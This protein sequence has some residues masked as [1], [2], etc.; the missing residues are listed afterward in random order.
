M[1]NGF[2]KNITNTKRGDTF[3]KH[4][5]DQSKCG[6][7][8]YSPHLLFV[9]LSQQQ[10]FQLSVL[11]R[12]PWKT[13]A[14]TA[15]QTV[16]TKH[17]C[18]AQPS[19]AVA[20]DTHWVPELLI[21]CKYMFQGTLACAHTNQALPSIAA[22]ASTFSTLCVDSASWKDYCGDC[23]RDCL[24]EALL[25]RTAVEN[26][27]RLHARTF[28]I[29]HMHVSRHNG[30]CAHKPCCHLSREG[31]WSWHTTRTDSICISVWQRAF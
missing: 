26:C 2:E 17:Y 7:F 24:N 10:L 28:N 9:F 23:T 5:N 31:R 13:I 21:F 18:Y 16:G 30:M 3:N 27:S 29:L 6:S 8:D 20:D 4:I 19:K 25:L 11:I 1:W 22:T 14:S 15:P 12:L